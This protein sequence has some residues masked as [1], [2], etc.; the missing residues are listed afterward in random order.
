MIGIILISCLTEAS[1]SVGMRAEAIA[2]PIAYYLIDFKPFLVIATTATTRIVRM[3]GTAST[4]YI[5]A[6]C[7]SP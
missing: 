5:H 1:L 7:L 4:Y 6:T 3:L 2:L